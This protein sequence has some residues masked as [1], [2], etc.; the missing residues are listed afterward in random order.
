MGEWWRRGGQGVG[1]DRGEDRGDWR[2]R[3]GQGVGYD[4]GEDRG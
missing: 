3:G 2:R 4:R 1:C